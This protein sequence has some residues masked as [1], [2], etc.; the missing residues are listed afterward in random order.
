MTLFHLSRMPKRILLDENLSFPS[1][2]DADIQIKFT[3][4]AGL[5][6]N[7]TKQG[8]KI[9]QVK[10]IVMKPYLWY[11]TVLERNVYRWV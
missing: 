10:F 1:A 3:V 5:N 4:A 8:L 7:S 9:N 2:A 6:Q 11:S